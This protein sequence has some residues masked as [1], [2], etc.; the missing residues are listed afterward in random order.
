M[1]T[2]IRFRR[3]TTAQ[4][5]TFIGAL[6]EVTVDTDKKTLVVHDGATPG[7]F[8]IDRAPVF[9]S[10]AAMAADTSLAI[11]MSV[12]VLGYYA[13]T[14][15]GGGLYEIVAAGTGTDDGGSFIDLPG[16][17]LQ[18][19]ADWPGHEVVAERF[20]CVN[21]VECAAQLNAASAFALSLGAA[22][23]LKAKLVMSSNIQ[24]KDP[25]ELGMAGRTLDIDF[26]GASIDCVTGGSLSGGNP[27]ITVYGHDSSRELCV[28]RCNKLCSGW[29]VLNSNQSTT[30]R[31][32]AY[33]YLGFG[34][35]VSGSQAGHMLYDPAGSEWSATDA[36]VLDQNNWEGDTLVIDGQDSTVIGGHPGHGLNALLLTENAGGNYLIGVHPFNGRL[37]DDAPA[38]TNSFS[39]VNH[40]INNVHVI[41]CYIDNG[42]IIDYSSTLNIVGGMHFLQL[43]SSVDMTNPMVRIGKQASAN[44]D[45]ATVSNFKSSVGLFEG[46]WDNIIASGEHFA[47]Y[48]QRGAGA[49]VNF[50]KQVL[51]F[52]NN[53]D[54]TGSQNAHV[55]EAFKTGGATN[56]LRKRIAFNSLNVDQ[57][58]TTDYWKI[59]TRYLRVEA[60][61][62]EHRI[63][64]GST[65]TG[66]GAT[67]DAVPNLSV[68]MNGTRAWNFMNTTMDLIPVADNAR[69]LGSASNRLS[70][71]YAATGTI[72]TSDAR[73]KQQVRELS[74]TE[75]AVAVKLKKLVRAFKFNDAVEAKGDKARV[76]FGVI[77]QDVIE[78]FRSEGLDASDYALLCYDEWDEQP[79]IKDDEGNV[80]QAY[81]VAGSRYGI[82]YEEF[83]AFLISAM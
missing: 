70:T 73:E 58:I 32:I 50:A 69:N 80:I 31:P 13:P 8:P 37:R 44:S 48:Y 10:V 21:G 61:D 59:G 19:Q 66:I 1:S 62:R 27:A 46:T 71:V 76:H 6:A 65:L 29:L 33:R 25:V 5:A 74:D 64:F 82:R 34:V 4:H 18:A 15:G 49:M 14:D 51:T 72:N 36:E 77:A 57:E 43:G 81:R 78:A 22:G 52:Y 42:Y 45:R 55:V 63:Y 54:V 67:Q 2:E 56:F 24:I 26:A 68:W 17:G 9:E 39:L 23:G 28:I 60:P 83:L 11:G 16:S 41:G 53:D 20:G 12:F 75:H 38:R 7:G 35:K 30:K 79:E 40:A 3:G 47:D